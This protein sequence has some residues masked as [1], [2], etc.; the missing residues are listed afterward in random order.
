MFGAETPDFDS[1]VRLHGRTYSGSEYEFRK[2]VFEVNMKKVVW[3]NSLNDGAQYGAGPFSDLTEDEFRSTKLGYNAALLPRN[4]TQAKLLDVAD[5]PTSIDW[6]AKG[7]VT[8]VKNQGQ[9]GSC[10]AFSATGDIE[11]A[12][13][14]KTG[15]TLC[16]W[17]P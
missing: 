16:A 2:G 7:A 13:F 5:T 14:V 8:P 9:C 10:W 1:F 12:T 3:L 15:S 11:G 17:G 4:A 6:R